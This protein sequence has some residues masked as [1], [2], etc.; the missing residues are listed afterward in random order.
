MWLGI[1]VLGLVVAM[2]VGCIACDKYMPDKTDTDSK[3]NQP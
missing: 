1:G 2:I 3:R